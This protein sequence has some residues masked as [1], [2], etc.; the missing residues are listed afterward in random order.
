MAYIKNV[1]GNMFVEIKDTDL[2][3][4]GKYH[5]KS[6]TIF[7]QGSKSLEINSSQNIY[8]HG[9]GEKI[10]LQKD[11][12]KILK[13]FSVNFRRPKDYEGEYGF[14]WLREE[15]I[16]PIIIV[17]H[18]N[19]GKPINIP[20]P[21]CNSS[22]NNL[23]LE[24]LKDVQ[25]PIKPYGV[26]YYPAWLSIFPH[27]NNQQFPHGSSMH[28]SG[29]SLD[30]QFDELETMVDDKTEI[31]LESSNPLLTVSPNKF[32]ISEVFKNKKKSRKTNKVINYYDLK[33][34]VNIKCKGGAL[35]KHEQ[36]RVFAKL[37]DKKV[38]VGKLMVYKNNVIPKAEFVVVNVITSKSGGK[39][40]LRHDYQHLLA[41]QSF[42]QAMI[43]AQVSADEVFDLTSIQSKPD[44]NDF[45]KKCNTMN[46][47]NIKKNFELLYNKYGKNKFSGGI[48]SSN[49]KKTYLFGTTLS[50]GLVNGSCSQ[51][52][53]G[54]WGN[55]YVVYKGGLLDNNT[56]VH[57]CA[58]SLS[59]PHVFE[60]AG[61]IK[62]TFF[63]GYTDNVM[64]YT[65]QKGL[66]TGTGSFYKSADNVYFGKMF[67]FFKW[68]WDILR[69]DESLITNY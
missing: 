54:A 8:S 26:D 12:N 38:E 2:T 11:S 39:A 28:A 43:R 45:L 65:W 66:P 42:N 4:A 46:S 3:V 9:H 52:S 15:Y 13:K 36:I 63:H 1:G 30:L 20:R 37:N 56:V 40:K 51:K 57:E 16:Y 6:G 35:T 24:Y 69:N 62:H 55:F 44:V 49:N 29:V 50:P 21:L 5:E 19:V 60:T 48:N 25:N 33:K 32:F 10:A 34:Q 14:D 22:I 61:T 58:H 41:K 27:T 59:L 47:E 7:Q 23:K 18:D 17:T 64:D 31:I 68:Q 67:A 53:N